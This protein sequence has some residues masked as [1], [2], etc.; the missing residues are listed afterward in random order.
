MDGFVI[1]ILLIAALSAIPFIIL[2]FIIKAA[3]R[4]GILEARRIENAPPSQDPLDQ[5]AQ[6]SCPS[7]G[8]KHD[9]D[10]PKCPYCNHRR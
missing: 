9:M 4:N 3:V 1:S 5:I 7:C 8:K 6:I 10:Y 2:Y